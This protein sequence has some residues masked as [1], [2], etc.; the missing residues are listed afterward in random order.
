[1]NS[2]IIAAAVVLLAGYLAFGDTIQAS[3]FTTPENFVG[4]VGRGIGTA[5]SGAATTLTTFVGI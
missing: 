5:I 1:M 2:R 3:W 4:D